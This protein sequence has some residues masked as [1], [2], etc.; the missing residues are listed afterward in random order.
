MMLPLPHNIWQKTQD[1]NGYASP[2]HLPSKWRRAGVKS[3][4]ADNS[5]ARN[6]MV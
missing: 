2:Q 5:S 1:G 4:S 3:N 6:P